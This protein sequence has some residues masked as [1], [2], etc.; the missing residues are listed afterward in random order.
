M[1][2]VP[3]NQL[4]FYFM[5]TYTNFK[6]TLKIISDDYA[7]LFLPDGT[8]VASGSRSHCWNERDH[9]E[10]VLSQGVQLSIDFD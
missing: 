7:E 5:V 3:Y 2:I 10:S 4:N 6:T 1:E 9:W 8:R